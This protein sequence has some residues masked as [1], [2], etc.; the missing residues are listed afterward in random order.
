MSKTTVKFRRVKNGITVTINRENSDIET[1]VYQR[2]DEKSRKEEIKAWVEFLYDL[3]SE[4]G[5]EYDRDSEFNSFTH[6][7]PGWDYSD[8]ITD[9]DVQ[10][11]VNTIAIL[12]DLVPKEKQTVE[13]SPFDDAKFTFTIGEKSE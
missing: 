12:C 13:P 8:D 9:E 6:M 4:L 5:P 11:D 7:L 2:H 3:T 1:L 10:D